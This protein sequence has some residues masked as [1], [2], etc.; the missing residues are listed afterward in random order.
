VKVLVTGTS[1]RIGGA[2][3]RELSTAHTVIGL[4]RVDAAATAIVAD[5][6][7]LTEPARWRSLLAGV[8]AVVHCA[9]L[10]AP[11]VGQ[12]DDALFETVNVQAT[13]A[14]A[15]A[16]IDAGVG[17]L[18]FTST[19]ALYGHAATP[20]GRAGWVTEETE[21]QPRTVY[22]RSKLRAEQA[23]QALAQRTG[24]EVTVLRVGR[25]FPEPA[26]AMAVY[27]LHRG[28]DARDLARAHVLAL[29]AGSGAAGAADAGSAAAPEPSAG[30]MAGPETAGSAEDARAGAGARAG[31]RAGAG[32]GEGDR[33]E[34]AAAAAAAP[35]A[36]HR[37]FIVSGTTPF[38]PADV[39]ALALD[40]PT[41]I[42]RRAPALARAFE[43]R[44]WALPASVDRVYDAGRAM[45]VLGWRPGHGFEAVLAQWDARR[46]E[47]LPPEGVTTTERP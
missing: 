17:R 38:E 12:V 2:V 47:V 9:A 14:L 20:P 44:G 1:G 32:A 45:R 11:D 6:A 5:L 37:C 26:P 16:C 42:R 36:R 22:H 15:R 31:A 27:R 40:A 4:D 28:V 46:P 18:V 29:G 30:T 8:D 7:A 35:T 19:T 3:W 25:C 24:L 10:H 21:P 23:L 34:A 41:V 33:A 13:E 43:R 39:Q